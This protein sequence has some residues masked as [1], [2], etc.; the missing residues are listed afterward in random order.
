MT[1]KKQ[2][3]PHLPNRGN[4]RALPAVA[5]LACGLLLTAG[6]CLLI[7]RYQNAQ[8][9]ERF[10]SDTA[11]LTAL[12][13]TQL[14]A[15]FETLLGVKGLFAASDT[16]DR[17]QFQRF[18]AQQDLKKN[19][20][21]FQAI[22]FVRMV[23]AAQRQ[24]YL[25]AMR[26]DAG[27]MPEG[28][29]RF[30]IKPPGARPVHYVIEFTVPMEGNGAAIGLDLAS[31]PSHLTALELGR[32]SGLPVATERVKLV[33]DP[34]GQA[35]FVMRVPLYRNGMP[36]QTVEQ[37]QLALLGFGAIVYRVGDL[38]KEVID[39]QLIPHM[40]IRIVDT[41]YVRGSGPPLAVPAPMF[42]SRE[43]YPEVVPGGAEL[44]GL[45]THH[46]IEIGQRGWRLDF[47]A[48]DGDR[49]GHNY[50]L[51]ASVAVSGVVISLLIAVQLVALDRRRVLAAQLAAALA[52][53]KAIVDNATVGIE[54]VRD[55]TIRSSNQGAAGM[56]GYEPAEIIGRSTRAKFPS[57][58][59]Y[60][61]FGEQVYPTLLTGRSWSGD[62]EWVRKDGSHT[63]CRLHGKLVDV[64][65]PD[66]DSIWVSYDIGAQRQADAALQAANADLQRSL[67]QVART[68]REVADLSELSGFLQACPALDDALDCIG[69]FALRL[70]PDSSGVVYMMEADRETLS[71]RA[72]W[73]PAPALP[74][75]T[76]DACWALRR[77][78]A[79]RMERASA[80]LCCPHLGA[81]HDAA[82]APY[83]CFPL[84]AQANTFGLLSI[85]HG[86]P[87]THA[88][89]ELRYQLATAMAEHI[90]LALANML[91]RDTL[92]QQ[93]V[94]DP[95]TGLH[96][97]RHLAEVLPRELARAHRS[98]AGL[99]VA[100][101]DV[102]HF[103][104][105]NDRHGHDAG[106][107]VL[108][109]V[110]QAML[111]QV[112]QGDLVC[113]YGGEEFVVLLTDIDVTLG[114]SRSEQIRL[115]ISQLAPAHLGQPLGQIT[116]SLGLAFYPQHGGTADS[117]LKSAD[118]ALYRAKEDGR[119]RVCVSAAP[120][121][122]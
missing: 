73:G 34:S 100:I 108:V 11:R 44:P 94:R 49:Y 21:G 27:S 87:A 83:A 3:A 25:D 52:E 12:T 103:K 55:R 98:G 67:A 1:D 56:L 68:Q 31:M 53:Q 102:D 119:N 82:D 28:A 19:H 95:L 45:V 88:A 17:R 96:N 33:Q 112:R 16:V 5:A 46:P 20:P 57:D 91:L 48:R 4:G 62:V 101:V 37:R 54:L 32:D 38:M 85:R 97:R 120:A 64:A 104:R 110:A 92:R 117:L 105:F 75:L 6:L 10:E 23:P 70:F 93:S 114:E 40:R 29:P 30:D 106:D 13:Q 14:L 71:A 50:L 15:H 111:A 76:A 43:A 22:Q 7:V 69:E 89:A 41:G 74:T 80:S 79:Y 36:T 78:K 18:L 61:A 121:P 47:V 58:E 122:A 8:L 2:Q 60:R 9:R 115:A 77:G 116:A 66:G 72:T 35:G 65:R 90:G 118:T 109:A 26:A 113:R 59:A 51:P 81:G 39:P 107:A 84:A 86:G 42:D 63:W 99:A 24:P